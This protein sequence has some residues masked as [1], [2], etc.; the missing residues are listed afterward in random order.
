MSYKILEQN[1]VD[2]ENID[3]GAFNN[4]SAG[5][6]DCIMGGVLSECSLSSVG[7]TIG[8]SPGVLIIHGIRVKI[9][10]TE[11]LSITSAPTTAIQYQIIGQII[12][13]S[14]RDIGFSLFLR[15]PEA[16]KKDNLY[17]ADQGTYQI[18]LGS[19]THDPSG[20]IKNLIRTLDVAYGGASG[21]M[22]LEVGN[23]ETETLPAGAEAKFDVNIRQTPSSNIGYLD[24]YAGIPQGSETDP[25]AVH[26]NEQNLTDMQKA[27]ARL[28]I[29]AA[30]E[31]S[32]GVNVSYNPQN[33]EIIIS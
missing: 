27:Q 26:F 8:I 33:E 22:L 20:T 32:G 21:G 28:N 16:L 14:N 24:F 7:N 3:G 9:T 29:G 19:F 30:A 4:F 6:R 1:G 15:L 17:T 13:S 12:L 23:V 10:D 11:I 2:N 18:E 25:Y 31:G 5:G